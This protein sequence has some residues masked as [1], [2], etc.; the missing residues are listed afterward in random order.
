MLLATASVAKGILNFTI[1]LDLLATAS[2]AKSISNFTILLATMVC[3]FKSY[4]ISVKLI[5]SAV[6]GYKGP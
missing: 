3:G 2:V 5:A 4:R 1:L 6:S